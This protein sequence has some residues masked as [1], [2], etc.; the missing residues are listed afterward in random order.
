MDTGNSGRG[1]LHVFREEGDSSERER[2]RS[3]TGHGGTVLSGA[4]TVI[5]YKAH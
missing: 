1:R 3:F 5:E 2:E 4:R